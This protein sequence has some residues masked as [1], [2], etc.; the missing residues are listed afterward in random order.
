MGYS[1]ETY[2]DVS[3]TYKKIDELMSYKTIKINRDKMDEYIE[4]FDKK[5]GK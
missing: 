3:K 2:L 4:F 5:Y 1:I